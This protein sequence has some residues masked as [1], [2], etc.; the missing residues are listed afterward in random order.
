MGSGLGDGEMTDG[1]AEWEGEVE[2]NGE[3]EVR[4]RRKLVAGDVVTL[5][6]DTY[7]VAWADPPETGDSPGGGE[8]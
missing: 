1:G 3:V 8:V 4:R 6:T 7:E 2:V 5:A